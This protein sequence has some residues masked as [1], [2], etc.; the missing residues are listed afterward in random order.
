[1]FEDGKKIEFDYDK[2]DFVREVDLVNKNH[3]F[4][5]CPAWQ[6]KA[7]RNFVFNSPDNVTFYV[8]RK[9]RKIFH[10]G[11]LKLKFPFKIQ[12]EDFDSDMIS[13]QVGFPKFLFWTDEK[14]VWIEMKNY[15]QTSFNNNFI[16]IGAWWNMSEWVR[17]TSFGLNIVD[18]NRPVIINKGDPIFM[19]SFYNKNLNDGIILEKCNTIPNKVL[20]EYDYCRKTLYPISK[21]SP[22]LSNII[23]GN[24]DKNKIVEKN[25]SKCP[26]KF[27]YHG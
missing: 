26:F 25:Q 12:D 2:K 23:F 11:A 17:D 13:L 16:T 15:S 24:V 27:L 10:T 19:V 7:N 18:E 8:D 20:D 1:M 3:S 14:N 22:T 21:K 9:N 4:A 5:K 6:H